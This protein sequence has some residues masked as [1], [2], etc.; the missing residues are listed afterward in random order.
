MSKNKKRNQLSITRWVVSPLDGAMQ[1][2]VQFIKIVV[3]LFAD[4]LASGV[5]EFHVKQV[6]ECVPHTHFALVDESAHAHLQPNLAIGVCDWLDVLCAPR[7][8][9]TGLLGQLY[10]VADNLRSVG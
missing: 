2:V 9:L 5:D 6:A 7:H 10:S 1:S 8:K 3:F 4:N